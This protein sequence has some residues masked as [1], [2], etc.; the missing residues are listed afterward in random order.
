MVTESNVVQALIEYGFVEHLLHASC[1]CWGQGRGQGRRQP[2]PVLQLSSDL[3][4]N[5]VHSDLPR[6]SSFS[7]KKSDFSDWNNILAVDTCQI[8]ECLAHFGHSYIWGFS[9]RY[10]FC[11]PEAETQIQLYRLSWNW[12]ICGGLGV[13]SWGPH[14]SPIQKTADQGDKLHKDSI[15]KRGK[16]PAVRGALMMFL[17]PCVQ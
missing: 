8:C 15:F 16:N 1:W 13:A 11:L 2:S 7:F 10:N 5:R 6:I 9:P 17:A 14:D 12:S 4:S 3:L